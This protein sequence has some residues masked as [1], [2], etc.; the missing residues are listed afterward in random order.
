MCSRTLWLL[1]LV[2]SLYITENGLTTLKKNVYSNLIQIGRWSRDFSSNFQHFASRLYVRHFIITTRG[3]KGFLNSRLNYY[4]NTPSTFKEIRLLTSG[5]ISLNPGSDKCSVCCKTVARHH[6]AFRCD[7]CNGW[8][9]IKC[10]NNI[11]PK[12]YETYQQLN[13]FNWLCPACINP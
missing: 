10:G 6:R 8:C 9:H 1:L 11:K 3:R 5:D 13:N 2:S 7:D 4:T 12:E